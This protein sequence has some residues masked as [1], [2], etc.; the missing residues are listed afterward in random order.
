MWAEA[1]FGVPTQAEGRV[2]ES[3]N[4]QSRVVRVEFDAGSGFA[5][6]DRVLGKG[7]LGCP[8][9]CKVPAVYPSLEFCE[10]AID[11][12]LDKIVLPGGKRCDCVAACWHHIDRMPVQAA[13]GVWVKGV[14]RTGQG[15]DL[16]DYTGYDRIVVDKDTGTTMRLVVKPMGAEK[17]T[18]QVLA[19]R[20]NALG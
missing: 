10:E 18:A 2:W 3:A 13:P 1:C 14:I 19:T 9:A 12:P 7:V 20:K 11:H 8:L 5:Q 6:V 15:V 17:L 4:H 16:Q